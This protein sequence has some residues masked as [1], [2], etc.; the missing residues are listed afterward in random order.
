[1][2]RA[3]RRDETEAPIVEGLRQCGYQVYL[4]QRPCD[5]LVRQRS[6]GVLTILEVNGIKKYRKREEAQLEFIQ[7]WQVPLV[8]TL[9]E[10]L[11]ALGTKIS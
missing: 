8:S 2:R 1:M 6:T 5:L 4:M 11:R 7:D 10:A 9:E 3:A